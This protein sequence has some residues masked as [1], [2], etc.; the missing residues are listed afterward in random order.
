MRIKFIPWPAL[1][2]RPLWW[3]KCDTEPMEVFSGMYACITAFIFFLP[4]ASFTETNGYRY[5]LALAPEWVWAFAFAMLGL[6]QS[7]A[8]CGNVVVFRYP[9]LI[10][11]IVLW[12]VDAILI[13]GVSPTTPGPWAFVLLAAGNLWALLRH[14]DDVG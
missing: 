1:N 12:G 11:G 14:G 6:L 4:F 3:W 9:A 5:H 2:F 10:L 13:L 8:M 7:L